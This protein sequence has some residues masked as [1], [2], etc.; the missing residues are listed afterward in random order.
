MA[1]APSGLCHSIAG[2][3]WKSAC[4]PAN[5]TAFRPGFPAIRRFPLA[6]GVA[7]A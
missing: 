5:L 2:I 4:M 1:R 3:P 6:A 7:A